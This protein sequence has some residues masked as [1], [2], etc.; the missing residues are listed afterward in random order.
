LRIIRWYQ[1]ISKFTPASCRY[2]PTC[3]EYAKWLYRFDNPI[4]ATLKSAKRIATCNQL[5]LGGIDYPK[6][7]KKE[8]SLLSLKNPIR[9]NY[10]TINKKESK[11]R[12][13]FWL[14]PKDNKF[15]IVK[16]FN[17]T[18]TYIPARYAPSP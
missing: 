4:L 8:F 16:D 6:I 14:I 10:L 12:I 13:E 17:A 9:A 18:A 2:Y 7:A 1:Y 3:S 11:L 5:F 15:L